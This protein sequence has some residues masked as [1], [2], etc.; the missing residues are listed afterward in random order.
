MA[1]VDPS[2]LSGTWL[3]TRGDELVDQLRFL[4]RAS[5][6]WRVQ[7]D[8][9]R[10]MI[11]VPGRTHEFDPGAG[12]TTEELPSTVPG[13]HHHAG[14]VGM[15]R[16]ARLAVWGRTSSDYAWTGQQLARSEGTV[17]LVFKR[18]PDLLAV[19]R[20]AMLTGIVLEMTIGDDRRELRDLRP[21]AA[22]DLFDPAATWPRPAA[23]G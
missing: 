2:E 12:W 7:E 4:Y 22:K 15:V 21:E 16:P 1:T 9:G 13:V 8:D 10:Q 11:V 18:P 19:L 14:L 17:T 20:I 23:D 5:G 3:R 6:W